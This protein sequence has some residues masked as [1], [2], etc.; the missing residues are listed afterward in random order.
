[1][2]KEEMKTRLS[3]RKALPKEKPYYPKFQP[4]VLTSSFKILNPPAVSNVSPR[5]PSPASHHV[6]F[7]AS[8][9]AMN[10]AMHA[11]IPPALHA[12][13]VLAVVS[14]TPAAASVDASTL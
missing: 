8:G 2:T 14:A 6:R 13:P 10:V 7:T 12:A 11:A 3:P 5:S 4:A 9:V 1:M